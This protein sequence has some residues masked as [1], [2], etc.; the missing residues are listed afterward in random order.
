MSTDDESILAWIY[1][2]PNMIFIFEQFHDFCFYGRTHKTENA[3][4]KMLLATAMIL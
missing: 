3:G 2:V 4:N 1:E